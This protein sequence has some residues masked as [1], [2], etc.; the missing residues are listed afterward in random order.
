MLNLLRH[1]ACKTSL[2]CEGW[3]G[4][5]DICEIVRQSLYIVQKF[6]I[7]YAAFEVYFVFNR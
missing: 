3:G 7:F 1:F 4:G 6:I 2:S 5:V